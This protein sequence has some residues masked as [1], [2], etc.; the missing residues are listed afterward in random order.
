MFRGHAFSPWLLFLSN[1]R[2]AAAFGLGKLSLWWGLSSEDGG[3]K[4]AMSCQCSLKSVA[5]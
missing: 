5:E 2:S 3:R 1:R 4:A